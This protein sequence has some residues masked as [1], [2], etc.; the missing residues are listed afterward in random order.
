MVAV[1][2]GSNGKVGHREPNSLSLVGCQSHRGHLRGTPK[3]SENSS[4]S[5]WGL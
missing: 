2:A 3:I 5:G 4:F 1:E